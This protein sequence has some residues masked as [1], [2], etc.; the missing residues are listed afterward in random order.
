MKSIFLVLL[1]L[2]YLPLPA[3][4]KKT[5]NPES[6]KPLVTNNQSVPQFISQAQTI[7][8]SSTGDSYSSISFLK[9]SAL[10]SL[11][12]M[13]TE[14]GSPAQ[15]WQDPN[16]PNN[17]HAIFSFA[18]V[19][20]MGT[21]WINASIQYFF[22]SNRGLT[23]SMSVVDT[24][25][26]MYGS[27]AGLSDGNVLIANN[28]GPIENWDN[29]TRVYVSTSPGSMSFTRLLPGGYDQLYP[30]IIGTASVSS[31]N[32][33]L[34]INTNS[35]YAQP[36]NAA[37]FNNGTS[38][39]ASSFSG[40]RSAPSSSKRSSL[41]R[42]ADGRF[43]LAYTI[44]GE[45]TDPTYGDV[46]FCESTDEGMTW[47]TPVL[48]LDAS[49][50]AGNMRGYL[51]ISVT[52]Q[53]NTPK[54]F[55]DAV[56]SDTYNNNGLKP[57]QIRF[58]SPTLPGTDPSRSIV[59]ADTTNTGVTSHSRGSGYPASMLRITRP[60][61]GISSDG[62]MIFSSFMV[63]DTARLGYTALV[64]NYTYYN[65]FVTVS[66]DGGS[67]WTAPEKINPSSPRFDWTYPSI[68]P[69]NDMDSN[70]YY[71][72]MLAQRDSVPGYWRMN[73]GI[74]YEE[75]TNANPYYIRVAYDRGSPAPPPGLAAPLNNTQGA[76]TNV[77]LQWSGV[78][79][80]L[81]YNIQIS[82]DAYFNNIVYSR[83]NVT[84]NSHAVQQG[85]LVLNTAYWWRVQPVRSSGAGMYS[86][87]WKFQTRTTGVAQVS[88]NIPAVYKLYNNYPNPFNP[89]TK[90]KFDLPKNSFVKIN[91]FDITGRL[92]N[93][94]LNLNLQPGSYETE[95][96][97][98]N[99]S[100]GVYYYRIEAGDFIETNKMILVK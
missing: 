5:L 50:S 75:F 15:I 66:S 60:V 14:G 98:M 53:N 25:R 37:F 95:F 3:Q 45:S 58:W 17:I 10:Q 13:Q 57:S 33:Y 89:T 87:G 84:G 61:S 72:N 80:A 64:G 65:I 91:I 47:S 11:N 1:A 55:F 86:D 8:Q 29:F 78:S 4:N 40:Y 49:A 9:L 20:M 59:I 32:K 63:L 54:V 16:N 38:L 39:A 7:P 43:G 28:A 51:G 99:L 52:Y 12:D 41:A 19:Q 48:I 24:G 92:V 26:C 21:L 79:N 56:S 88:S 31:A 34:L 82:T 23:W 27:L 100:S 96:N 44:G 42:G 70:Y 77:T 68:S 18:P 90:I 6:Q 30:L 2:L 81:S 94:L 71:L 74:P 22:S 93:E 69:V 67:T 46:Y 76:P 35:I 97:G 83:T 36:I 73:R 85:T 62:N